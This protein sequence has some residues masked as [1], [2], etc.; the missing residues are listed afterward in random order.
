MNF[1]QLLDLVASN[2]PSIRIRFSTSHPKDMTNDVLHIMAKHQNICKYI[3]LPV[4]SGSSRILD[5][6][7][8]GYSREWYLNRI[9]AIKTIIPN[10]GISMDIITG[11]CTESKEDHKERTDRPP[12]RARLFISL[13]R[14]HNKK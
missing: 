7:N 12:R 13:H 14:T 11:F 5:L 4:Q 2:C 1:A 3:H 6:M 10:C 8:R 9:N